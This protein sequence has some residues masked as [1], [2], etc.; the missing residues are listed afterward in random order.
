MSCSCALP[1]SRFR[2]LVVILFLGLAAYRVVQ[3][4]CWLRRHAAE[5]EFR[6]VDSLMW[7]AAQALADRDSTAYQEVFDQTLASEK[8]F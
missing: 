3:G 6:R 2:L 8:E 4:R 7:A 5:L 1:V